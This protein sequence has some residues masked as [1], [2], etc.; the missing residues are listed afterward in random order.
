MV[1][2]FLKSPLCRAPY[3]KESDERLCAACAWPFFFFALPAPNC[4]RE[5]YRKDA[6]R[7]RTLQF[8]PFA[9]FPMRVRDSGH[10]KFR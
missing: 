4:A 7:D 1:I 6:A 3:E 10:D 8:P 2:D 5:K 9:T